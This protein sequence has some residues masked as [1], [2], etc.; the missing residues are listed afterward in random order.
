M[1][2]LI[3]ND[4]GIDAEGI[5]VLSH[6]LGE[7]Y[8]TLTV[9]PDRNRSGASNSLTLTRPLRPK[10]VRDNQYSVD[11]T[12]TD[13]VNLV[14]SGV[15][16]GKVDMVVS[17]IN[18]GP[19]LGDDVI[20]SGTVAA[21]MEARHLGRPALAVSLVGHTHFSTAAQIVCDILERHG[22]LSVPVG[23]L[24]NINV[25]D[26]PYEEIKGIQVTRLGHRKVAQPAIPAQDPRGCQSFWIGALSEPNDNQPGTDFHAIEQGYVSITPIHTD[27]TCHQAM[28]LVENWIKKPLNS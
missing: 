19:N 22:D 13:C 10:R 6:F 28:G 3:A 7:R 5:Q 16:D 15:I 25:P 9:A 18:H 17:G 8:N 14:M 1:R 2:I 26:L 12:P 20:Y 4:D 11:G 21:A 27:M 23:T 24:L